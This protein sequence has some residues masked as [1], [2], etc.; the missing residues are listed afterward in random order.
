MG[1]CQF[2]AKRKQFSFP[3][4]LGATVP[5][6]DH[7]DLLGVTLT[8]TFNFAPYIEAK[9]QLAAKKLGILAMVRQ[10]YFTPEQLLTL[11]QVQVRSCME[12]SSA[13]WDGSARYQLEALEAIETRAK[14][15]IGNDALV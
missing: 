1:Q 5:I 13:L 14:K 10:L 15:I 9:A 4:F 8:S 7:L 12:Y 6:T 3:T 2:C 11:Y